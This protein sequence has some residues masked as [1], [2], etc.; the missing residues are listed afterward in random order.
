LQF[1]DP[2]EDEQEMRRVRDVMRG[3]SI[4]SLAQQNLHL[5]LPASFIGNQR[6]FHYDPDVPF[7]YVKGTPWTGAAEFLPRE[8]RA[9]WIRRHKNHPLFKVKIRRYRL[10]DYKFSIEQPPINR[11]KRKLFNEDEHWHDTTLDDMS[12]LLGMIPW[13]LQIIVQHTYTQG[14]EHE[15]TR[16]FNYDARID[17]ATQGVGPV[18]SI[19]PI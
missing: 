11:K 9:G 14:P 2:Y 19:R 6:R 10:R 15:P 7:L 1:E 12:Q 16:V 8:E 3:K 4:N 5:L 13:I 17:S 18:R